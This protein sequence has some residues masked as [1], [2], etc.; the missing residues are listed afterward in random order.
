[1]ERKC[2]KMN[3][4]FAREGFNVLSGIALGLLGYIGA[5]LLGAVSVAVGSLTAAQS[6]IFSS[7]VFALLFIGAVLDDVGGKAYDAR[8]TSDANPLNSS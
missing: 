5:N 2:N 1:M 7:I 6:T 3:F 4:S 8:A